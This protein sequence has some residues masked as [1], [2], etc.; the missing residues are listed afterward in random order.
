MR[1]CEVLADEVRPYNIQVNCMAPGAM[2]T[3]ILDEILQA[4]AERAGEKEYAGALKIRQQGGVLPERAAE[5]AVFLASPAADMVTGKLISAVWDPWKEFP[6]HQNELQ[7]S[8]IY[9]LRRIIP[10]DRGQ[11]WGD[12]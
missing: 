8:D 4:G 1:F 11:T 9:T 2:S 7:K 10:S 3:A 5:L 6:E 12:V